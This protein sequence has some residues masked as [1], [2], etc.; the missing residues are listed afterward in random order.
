MIA[1]AKSSIIDAQGKYQLELSNGEY[2]VFFLDKS[3]QEREKNGFLSDK[4]HS[5][6]LNVYFQV[7]QINDSDVQLNYIYNY[8]VIASQVQ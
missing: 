7:E 2:I 1:K 3:N 4:S 5:P 6:I 8:S